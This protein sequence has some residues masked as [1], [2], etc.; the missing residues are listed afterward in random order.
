MDGSGYFLRLG[1]AWLRDSV[2]PRD[3]SVT[4]ILALEG[5]QNANMP[6]DVTGALAANPTARDFFNQL[7]TFYR[8][9][10]LR[11]IDGN[12]KPDVRANRISELIALL[13]AGKR[14]R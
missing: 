8:K 9:N 13:A 2:I 3:T 4:V 6:A 14:A 12:K 7:P 10:Y 11:W 1:P 5:P